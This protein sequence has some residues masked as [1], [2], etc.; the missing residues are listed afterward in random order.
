MTSRAVLRRADGAS[1][2]S[3]RGASADSFRRAFLDLHGSCRMLRTT[4]PSR[5][6]TDA[7]NQTDR[8]THRA[9]SPRGFLAALLGIKSFRIETPAAG[10]T[11]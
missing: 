8:G 4:C 6:N 7:T 3:Q 1:R 5:L 10:E 11:L 9:L 2:A